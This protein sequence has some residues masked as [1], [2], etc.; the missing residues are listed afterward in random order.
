MWP[1]VSP[2]AE[3][4]VLDAI[5]SGRWAISSL[6]NGASLYEQRFAKEFAEY[7][8]ADFCIPTDHG[9]SA[10]VIALEALGADHGAEVVIPAMTWTATATAVFRAG[11][12]PVIA[13]VDPE[14]GCL[15]PETIGEA[16]SSRTAA[17]IVVHWACVMA[18]I[19]AIL[20]VA[21][22]NSLAVIEDA[23][24]AHGAAWE[25]KRAGTLGHFGC[26]SMQHAKV[27]TCGEGG[28]VVTSDGAAARRLEE[29]RADSRSYRT[30]PAMGQLELYESAS[31]M[32]ANFGIDEISAAL[33]VAQLEL[34]P[35]QQAKR[36]ANYHLLEDLLAGCDDVT[37]LR[38]DPRQDELSLYE[39]PIIFPRQRGD[40][41]QLATSLS[42][43][44][45]VRV[46][47]PRVPLHRSA[48]LQ[49]RTKPTLGPL[50]EH[51]IQRLGQRTFPGAEH[52]A[53]SAVLLHHSA[54]LASAEHIHF[55]AEA[56][57]N[58]A[59]HDLS[60]A[61]VLEGNIA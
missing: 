45:G 16:I 35:A 43:T 32:G 13:D 31:I 51:Y 9:S 14:T 60:E 1:E 30:V 52:L 55:I 40:T 61:D 12:V 46:Y 47:Q 15:T 48:L 2:N 50:A 24:Q 28:A 29:L 26:F 59:A 27:L 17:I 56:V 33:L 58:A 25:G 5:R 57:K 37:L 23:A 44:L 39:V 21:E 11:L 34:L 4:Y 53:N 20:R 36:T 3:G 10:L 54:F 19:P 18:D 22:R 38:R 8:G 49:P 6:Y 41:E 42:S 7:L